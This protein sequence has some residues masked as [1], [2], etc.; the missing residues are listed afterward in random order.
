MA[1]VTIEELL[2]TTSRTFAL[3]IPLLPSP[4]DHKITLSYLVFRIADTLEDAD[5]LDR[6]DRQRG[7]ASFCDVLD[8]LSPLSAE[9]WS[10]E[11]SGRAI[12]D[13]E[14]Y[15]RLLRETPQIVAAVSDIDAPSRGAIVHHAKRSAF[16]M[17]EFLG[18]ADHRANLQLS[19]L[20]D[21]RRYC[22]FVAGIVGELITDLFV[23]ERE[24]LSESSAL[25]AH[26]AAFGEGLQLVNILK[27]SSDDEKCGR[28]YLP[29]QVPID[30]V[31]ELA[32]DDLKQADTYV[33]TL[34]EMQA[35]PGYI[36]FCD[37]P[38]QL[39]QAT[40]RVV[41]EHGPGSKVPRDEMFALLQGVME[42]AGLT[43]KEVQQ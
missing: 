30:E 41:R 20:D 25:R 16:G 7:L 3:S 11:W 10:L 13:N 38:V 14:H 33:K 43:A 39:A 5:R 18:K 15:N 28:A 4:L 22:Y 19:S 29:P 42:R 1:S 21:L 37:A 35:P 34:R 36:A 12:S 9:Q 2:Q 31:F 40:L 27:D 32:L 26:A 6:S 17:A 23:I 8:D 24:D